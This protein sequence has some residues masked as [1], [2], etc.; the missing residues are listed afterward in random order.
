M[1]TLSSLL[2]YAENLRQAEDLSGRAYSR[3]LGLAENSWGLYVAGLRRPGR[4]VLT[5]LQTLHPDDATLSALIAD[6]IRHPFNEE[7]QPPRP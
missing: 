6:Y 5:A 7:K 4:R 3:S 2:E 1:G